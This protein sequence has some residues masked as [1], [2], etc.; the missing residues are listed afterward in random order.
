M[1]RWSGTGLRRFH[2]LAGRRP[3]RPAGHRDRYPRHCC[4]TTPKTPISASRPQTKPA[5]NGRS[6]GRAARPQPLPPWWAKATG[7]GPCNSTPPRPARL[8]RTR[9]PS[10]CSRW[11]AGIGAVRRCGS[12][13]A[14]LGWRARSPT[15][16]TSPWIRSSLCS[17]RC[18]HTPLAFNWGVVINWARSAIEGRNAQLPL[19]HVK[20]AAA[21]GWLRHV[22]FS[23]CSVSRPSSGSRG[24]TCTC[25]WRAPPAPRTGR[26]WAPPRWPTSSRPPERSPTG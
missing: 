20:A 22:G 3:A 21:A 10:R 15:R 4:V 14:T 6:T 7:S 13:T 11:P 25:L 24:S 26:C 8:T 23:S 17:T 12:S 19:D 16:A 1:A 9:S 18:P 2:R 5:A